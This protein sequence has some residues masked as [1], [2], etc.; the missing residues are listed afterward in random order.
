[1]NL[2][3]SPKKIDE[4]LMVGG[5]TVLIWMA[6]LISIIVQNDIFII[7]FT[8]VG[9]LSFL[10]FL[11]NIDPI[12]IFYTLCFGVSFLPYINLQL[13]PLSGVYIVALL[14]IIVSLVSL[15]KSGTRIKISPQIKWMILFLGIAGCSFLWVPDI[16][17]A[18]VYWGQF[19]VY[20][21]I[22]I[23]TINILDEKTK[24][25]KSLK[26]VLYGSTIAIFISAVQFI[27]SLSSINEVINIFYESGFGK[28]LIGTKGIERIGESAVSIL[29]RGSNIAE[30]SNIVLFRVFGT[31]EGPTSFG[32]YLLLGGLL[33]AALYL[34]QIKK[35]RIG[36]QPLPN[37]ILFASFSV[38]LFFTFTRSAILAFMIAIAFILMYRNSK[39]VELFSRKSVLFVLLIFVGP[40]V[41]L[42]LFTNVLNLRTIGGST[43]ARLLTIIFSV[44]YIY[45]NPLIG[46]GIGNYGY[47]QPGTNISSSKASL[48][49]AHNTYLELGVELGLIGIII[50]LCI[51]VSY[52]KQA[53]MLMKAS[54]KSFYH[55][56]GLI[57]VSIWIG[58]IISSF[59]GGSLIHPRIMT[60]LWLLAGIQTASYH[61][62][63]NDKKKENTIYR[64]EVA[65]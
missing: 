2:S 20:T 38:C 34:G 30:S 5:L 32:M 19:F 26:Y 33:A 14:F 13:F 21:C 10:F 65:D 18:I 43:A 56:I 12:H 44:N 9:I 55:T 29:N 3:V 52:I 4:Y 23:A 16:R 7:L 42:F 64:L 41:F 40:V 27:I 31:F 15:L 22:C 63:L 62:Y 61:L 36:L 58:F 6:G 60:L 8:T 48:A 49:S 17:R 46:I 53:A 35:R 45:N 54:V 59:F 57:F 39:N 47:A 37:I 1:M 51:L 25:I 11:Q 28:L 24:I 50:F